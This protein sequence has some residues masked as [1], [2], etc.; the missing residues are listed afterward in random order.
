MFSFNNA[1]CKPKISWASVHASVHSHSRNN[2]SGATKLN[3]NNMCQSEFFAEQRRG[4]RTDWVLKKTSLE[5]VQQT[6]IIRVKFITHANP[7]SPCLAMQHFVNTALLTARQIG[8]AKTAKSEIELNGAMT[9]SLPTRN[10]PF[11]RLSKLSDR[12]P[13]TAPPTAFRCDNKPR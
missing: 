12:R 2:T 6:S 3:D 8:F 13:Q 4:L 1:S 9:Q 5:L 7:Y 10:T 11:G